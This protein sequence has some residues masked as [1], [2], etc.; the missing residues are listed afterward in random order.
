MKNKL[1]ARRFFP[2]RMM[3]FILFFLTCFIF[4]LHSSQASAAAIPYYKIAMNG[5][6]TINKDDAHTY[7]YVEFSPKKDGGITFS[8]SSN[9]NTTEFVM[10]MRKNKKGQYVKFN[11]SVDEDP[12]DTGYEDGKKNSVSYGVKKGVK[13][14]LRVELNNNYTLQSKFKSCKETGGK[15]QSTAKSIKKG[16]KQYGLLPTGKKQM[17]WYK[18]AVP[19]TKKVKVTFCG[20]SNSVLGYAI[21]TKGVDTAIRT[22]ITDNWDFTPGKSAAWNN[23]PKVMTAPLEK[24]TVVYL[25]VLNPN[26]YTGGYYYFKWE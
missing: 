17:R 2:T 12:I 23:K 21:K 15:K 10:L 6:V 19:K 1:P 20:Y 14:A 9:V 3:L 18:F 8:A 4:C 5:K 7:G 13:Y 22:V 16:K 11:S 24:G 26:K 25:T